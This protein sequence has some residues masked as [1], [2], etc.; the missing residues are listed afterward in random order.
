MASFGKIEEFNVA[1]EEWS[2]YTERVTQY[3]IANEITDTTKRRAVLLSVCGAKTYSLMRSLVS[4]DKP[5]DKTYTELCEL[6]QAYYH[7]KPSPIV[8][9]FKFN[10]LVRKPGQS[11]AEFVA[12]LRHIA[13]H[14]DYGATLQ[15]MLRDRLVCGIQDDRIQ[16]RLLSESALDFKKAMELAQGIE[17]AT[18]NATDIQVLKAATPQGREEKVHTVQEVKPKRTNQINR[19]VIGDDP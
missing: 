14:C 8:Q 13:E 3:F 6:M 11:V 1:D 7:P 15:E 5:S 4:P 9:R 17:I 12:D 18:K 16:R 10:S 2:Q 19:E